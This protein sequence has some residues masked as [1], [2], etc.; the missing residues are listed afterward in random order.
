MK[1]NLFFKILIILFFLFINKISH[2]AE[3]FTFTVTEIEVLD[4]GNKIIG[5]NRGI[6][7]SN[8]K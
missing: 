2:S 7:K 1:N 3:S 4:N 5:T 8:N 6:I